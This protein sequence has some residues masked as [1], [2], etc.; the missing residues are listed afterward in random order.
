MLRRVLRS[1]PD[2]FAN[3]VVETLDENVVETLDEI[4]GGERFCRPA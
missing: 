3:N 4:G 1:S 2:R